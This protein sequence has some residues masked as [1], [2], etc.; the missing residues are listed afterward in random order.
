MKNVDIPN[1]PLT[2]LEL[3]GLKKLISNWLFSFFKFERQ[4]LYTLIAKET[5]F[6]ELEF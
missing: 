2:S 4:S 1:W 5:L 6:R 3:L